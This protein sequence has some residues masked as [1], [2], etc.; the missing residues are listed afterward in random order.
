MEIFYWAL[1]LLAFIV[2]LA[3]SIGL[4]EA[5][6]M[7]VAKLFKLSVPRFFVGF[8]PTLWSKKTSKTEYG[9]KAIPLGGFVM[10]E[11]ESREEGDPERGMLS[12]VSPWKRI[13]VFLAGPIVNLIIGTVILVSVLMSYPTQYVTNSVVKIESCSAGETS[14]VVCGAKTAGMVLGDKIVSVNGEKI[15]DGSTI[16]P[17]IKDKQTINIVVD[18][19]GSLV[20]L[21]DVPV[22]NGKIG[23]NLS[24]GERYIGMGEAFGTLGSVMWQNLEALAKIPDKVPALVT[25]IAGSTQVEDVPASV[26]AVGKTYGDVSASTTLTGDDKVRTLLV[27]SG[28]LNIGLGLINLLFIMPLDGGRIMIALFDALRMGYSKLTGFTKRKWEYSPISIATISNLTVVT[29]SVVFGFMGLVI[30]SDIMQI[31]RGQI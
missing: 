18:R 7:G 31:I 10:I 24:M 13:S 29:A 26:V 22:L 20:T 30:V 11:D 23:I 8:G 5:G 15:E 3:L 1:G 9:I 12:H 4:H 16:S 27:Y 14:D 25:N 28:L 21:S 19:R 6:H 2:M 17:L